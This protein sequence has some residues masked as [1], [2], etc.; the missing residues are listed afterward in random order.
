MIVRKICLAFLTGAVALAMLAQA[1]PSFAILPFYDWRTRSWQRSGVAPVV[2]A[3]VAVAPAAVPMMAAPSCNPCAT[4]ACSPCA[5]TACSPV[6]A[7]SPCTTTTCASPV[8][9]YV[10]E[11]AY[12]VQIVNTPVTTFQPVTTPGACG[13]CVTTLMPVTT[14]VAQT[15]QV[16]FT[17]YRPVV[18]FMPA[19]CATCPTSPCAAGACATGA[20]PTGGCA[21]GNC[22]SGACGGGVAQVSG[23]IDEA[24]SLQAA[25]IPVQPAPQQPIVPQPAPQPAPQPQPE[26]PTGG[27]SLYPEAQA[28]QRPLDTFP[29]SSPARRATPAPLQDLK[30]D[31]LKPVAPPQL[32]DPNDKTASLIPLP[33]RTQV[34]VVND[35]GWRAAR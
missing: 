9:N 14:M 25:P 5:T 24:P 2:V 11:T 23:T 34:R 19:P 12:R 21:T 4:T 7:C 26:Q 30:Q 6:T 29:S 17:T 10:A 27:P 28:M 18:S 35:G 13:T 16:P 33:Q 3:P 15:Q 8:V 31:G 32:L 22:P 20:C 1:T